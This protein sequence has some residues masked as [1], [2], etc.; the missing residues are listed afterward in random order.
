MTVGGNR[1]KCADRFGRRLSSSAMVAILDQARLRQAT[2]PG[3]RSDLNSLSLKAEGRFANKLQ[4][5]DCDQIDMPAC[6]CC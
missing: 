5:G 4:H 2:V 6:I 3:G 1:W